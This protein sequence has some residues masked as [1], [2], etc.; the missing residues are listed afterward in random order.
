MEER[1][2]HPDVHA[3][4]VILVLLFFWALPVFYFAD[5]LAKL[6]DVFETTDMDDDEEEEED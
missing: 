2:K 1:H 4:W 3:I 5:F 6:I